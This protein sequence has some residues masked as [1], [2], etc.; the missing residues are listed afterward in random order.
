MLLVGA[1]VLGLAPSFGSQTLVRDIVSGVFYLTGAA[2]RVGEYINREKAEGM[3]ESFT[4]RS[5][6]RR[7]QN[8]QIH[9]VPF[10]EL[11]HVTNCNLAPLASV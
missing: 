4:L 1:S 11:C 6:Q 10:G 3:V 5:V 2:F 9:T 8:G 7:N